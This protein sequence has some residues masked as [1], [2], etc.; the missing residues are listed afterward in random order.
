MPSES[1]VSSPDTSLFIA[2]LAGSDST[3]NPDPLRLLCNRILAFAS[4]EA[5]EVCEAAER[6]SSNEQ[7]SKELTNETSPSIGPSTASPC[8][9]YVN[10]VWDEIS[11]RL[12][13]DLGGQIFFVGRTDVFHRNYSLFHRFISSFLSLAP[14]ARAY[15]S[16]LQ[17]PSYVAFRRRW[18]LP[19][20]FQMRFREVVGKLEMSLREG[21]SSY[22]SASHS[23]EEITWSH[24]PLLRAPAAVL[25]AFAFPWREGVHLPELAS[26]EWKLSLQVLSRF[27]SW[28][29]NELAQDQMNSHSKRAEI[30]RK[31]GGGHSRAASGDG[32]AVRGSLDGGPRVSLSSIVDEFVFHSLLL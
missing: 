7:G 16:L 28:L 24:S 19:V 25:S 6:L 22:T 32:S 23:S 2:P 3:A 13:D 15:Q 18:Q 30:L 29:D 12:M 31:Q 26:R 11:R 9:I 14:S 20:Y 4:Q 1:E 5:K 10:V 21:R 17:H 27:K 8:D